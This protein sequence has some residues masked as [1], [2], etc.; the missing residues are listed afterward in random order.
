VYWCGS[1]WKGAATECHRRWPKPGVGGP[2]TEIA[3]TTGIAAHADPAGTVPATT[4]DVLEEELGHHGELIAVPVRECPERAEE[5]SRWEDHRQ[6][7]LQELV[8][9]AISAAERESGWESAAATVGRSA[10]ERSSG[11]EQEWDDVVAAAAAAACWEAARR[12]RGNPCAGPRDGPCRPGTDADAFEGD[13]SK[14]TGEVVT[15]L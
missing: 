12:G 9:C 4:E 14:L 3:A 10:E 5:L 2:P 13:V 11:A 6:K 7:E 15:T 1:S 8:V